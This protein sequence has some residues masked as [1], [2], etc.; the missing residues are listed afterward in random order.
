MKMKSPFSTPVTVG[1]T[2]GS[3]IAVSAEGTDVPMKFF[4]ASVEAGC[5]PLDGEDTPKANVEKT[6]ADLLRE[7]LIAMIE[8]DNKDDF[9]DDGLPKLDA[10]SAKA[11]RNV[12]DVELM[13]AWQALQEEAEK[14]E[15]I[16]QAKE[17]K[18]KSPHMMG[19]DTLK[20]KIAEAKA[21]K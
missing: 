16:K 6:Q 19:I 9:R 8:S 7:L 15:L 12:E 2:D 18:I 3:C 5:L 14:D 10:V 11:G 1:L 17:L 13:Q 20:A 21:G 4:Q